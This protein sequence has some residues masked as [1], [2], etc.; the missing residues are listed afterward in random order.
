LHTH[1]KEADMGMFSF[2]KAAGRLLGIAGGDA[3]QDESKPPPPPPQAE[4]IVAELKRQGLSAQ[5]V[6][7]TVDGDKVHVSGSAPDAATREKLIL[8]AGNIAGIA[9]VQDQ[10]T[11]NTSEPEAEFHTVVRGET[12]SA[13]AKKHYGN[14]NA[15][16][17][18]FEANK[19][20]LKDP[21]HIYPGQV[22][23]IPA[24]S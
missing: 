9:S 22:L 15:Y 19:P 11:T 16:M 8:A 24:K 7:V 21:D 10:I 6:Q 1:K 18:I 4:A 20:M 14:A 3:V 17:Q 23:R 5:D 12:L 2:V 13:I